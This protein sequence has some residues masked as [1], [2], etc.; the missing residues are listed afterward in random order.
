[1][2]THYITEVET[3]GN[4]KLRGKTNEKQDNFTATIMIVR[5]PTTYSAVVTSR[6]GKTIQTTY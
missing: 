5:V 3:V 6:Q 4:T 2:H 1:M